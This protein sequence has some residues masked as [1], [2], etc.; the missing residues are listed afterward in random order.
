MILGKDGVPNVECWELASLTTVQEVQRKDGSIG[1][2]T[3]TNLSATDDRVSEVDVL[4]FPTD[5]A[6]YPPSTVDAAGVDPVQ[7]A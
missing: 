7:F 1:L 3:Q 2:M 4:T 6:L 5:S